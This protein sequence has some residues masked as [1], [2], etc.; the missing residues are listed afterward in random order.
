[1]YLFYFLFVILQI[2]VAI[3]LFRLVKA[4]EG[5]DRSLSRAVARYERSAP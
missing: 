2:A 4:V 1:M 3:F 5:I